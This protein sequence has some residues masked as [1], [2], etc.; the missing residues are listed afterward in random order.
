MTAWRDSIT[1]FTKCVTFYISYWCLHKLKRVIVVMLQEMDCRGENSTSFSFNQFQKNL[2]RFVGLYPPSNDVNIILRI[3]YKIYSVFLILISSTLVFSQYV[4]L[5]SKDNILE[6]VLGGTSETVGFTM[7]LL[8]TVT[9]MYTVKENVR[10]QTMVENSWK[11]VYV[12]R[13]SETHDSLVT[14]TERSINRI[15][16][17]SCYIMFVTNVFFAGAPILTDHVNGSEI[18]TEMPMRIWLPFELNSWSR[19]ITMYVTEWLI[20]SYFCCAMLGLINLYACILS[21][22][23][24]QFK[25]LKNEFTKF[26]DDYKYTLVAETQCNNLDTVYFRLKR[27]VERHEKLLR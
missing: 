24:A 13:N 14:D 6:S 19:R 11:T 5:C 25:I 4:Y 21:L 16:Y 23:S 20:I 2:L 27:N 26:A 17:A 22:L 7:V 8:K 10:I 12:Q 18:L 15:T 9:F 1:L 3:V